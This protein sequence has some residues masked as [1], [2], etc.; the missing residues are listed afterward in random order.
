MSGGTISI[1]SLWKGGAFDAAIKV[2]ALKPTIV[3]YCEIYEEYIKHRSKGYGYTRAIELT[4]EKLILTEAKVRV[5]V[6]T[7]V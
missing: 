1:Y 4:A 2:D 7:V 5:A 6:A 3:H